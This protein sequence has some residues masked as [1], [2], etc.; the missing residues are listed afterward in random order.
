MDKLFCEQSVKCLTLHQIW[1]SQLEF[2]GM[3]M[4]FLLTSCYSPPPCCS[5]CLWTCLTI[6]HSKWVRWNEVGQMKFADNKL[7]LL[8]IT[9]AACIEE[10]ESGALVPALGFLTSRLITR[11]IKQKNSNPQ[12]SKKAGQGLYIR[13]RR[14][15]EHSKSKSRFK[16][17]TEKNKECKTDTEGVCTSYWVFA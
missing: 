10:K 17:S 15:R 3:F 14:E 12:Q 5:R 2:A 16:V 8:E 1:N 4:R 9:L 6:R 11:F 7:L 13:L